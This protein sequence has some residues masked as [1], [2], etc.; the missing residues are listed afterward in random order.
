MEKKRDYRMNPLSEEYLP[1]NILH[2]ESQ[3]DEIRECFDIFNNTQIG[4]LVA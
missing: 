1:E 3:L 2:R 4:G